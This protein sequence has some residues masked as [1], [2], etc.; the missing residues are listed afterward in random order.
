[1]PSHHSI[2][3]PTRALFGGGW[4]RCQ[5][6]KA[7]LLVKSRLPNGDKKVA[8]LLAA[9]LVRNAPLPEKISMLVQVWTSGNDPKGV[10]MSISR[11]RMSEDHLAPRAATR[12]RGARRWRC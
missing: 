5:C 6:A 4:R 11:S 3:S 1:M 2:P 9:S 10:R 8:A 12:L 7:T